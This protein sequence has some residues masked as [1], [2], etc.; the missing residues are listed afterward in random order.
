MLFRFMS[1][2]KMKNIRMSEDTFFKCVPGKCVV[3]A[4]EAPSESC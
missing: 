4:N 2:L 3:L 1:D